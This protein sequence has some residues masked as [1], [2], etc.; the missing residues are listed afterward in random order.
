MQVLL[1]PAIREYGSGEVVEPG[2]YMD[3]ESGAVVEVYERD[4]LP[5]GV[6]IVQYARRFRRLDTLPAKANRHP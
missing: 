3:V 6:R 4:E 5:Q 2:I 1:R